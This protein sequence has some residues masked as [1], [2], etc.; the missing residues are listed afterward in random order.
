MTFFVSVEIKTRGQFPASVWNCDGEFGASGLLDA[1]STG[2]C[3]ANHTTLVLASNMIIQGI[4][5]GSR[6]VIKGTE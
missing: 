6:S 2:F 4:K 3:I 5:M 1:V